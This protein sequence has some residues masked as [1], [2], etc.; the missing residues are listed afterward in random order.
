MNKF[1]KKV[2]ST[3][4]NVEGEGG[5]ASKTFEKDTSD[6]TLFP[7]IQV[8]DLSTITNENTIIAL[9]SDGIVWKSCSSVESLYII[10]KH[11]TEDV[12]VELDGIQKFKGL[13]KKISVDSWL[14]V[15]NVKREVSG[16]PLWTADDFETTQYNRLNYDTE[17]K[18]WEQ[19]QIV[20][21]TK[22]KNL[23]LQFGINKILMVIGSG[24]CFREDLDQVKLYKGTRSPLRPIMLERTR[25]WVIEELGGEDTPKGFETDDKITWLAYQSHLNYVK[26]GIH[27]YLA[28]AEDKDALGTPC[29]LA[30]F[31]T[32]SGKD[33]PKRGKF[34]YPNAWLIGDTSTGVGCLDLVVNTKKE[35]KGTGLIWLI[36][37]SFLI[38]DAADG[39]NALKHLPQKTDYADVKAYKDFADLK[40]P[41]EVLQK[42]VDLYAEFFPYGVQYT[43]HKGEDL[44]IDTMTYMNTYMLTA[45]MTRSQNDTM[46]FYKLC[47]AFKVDTSKVVNNNTMTPPKLTFIKDKAEENLD[48]LKGLY[49]DML[50]DLKGFKTKKKDDLVKIIGTIVE[51]HGKLG[52]QFDNFYEMKSELKPINKVVVKDD[53]TVEEFLTKQCKEKG[54]EASKDLMIEIIE[55]ADIVWEDSYLDSHRWYDLR[56]VVVELKGRYIK[57]A[58]YHMTGDNGMYDMGLEYS[59]SDFYFVTQDTRTIEET[60]YVSL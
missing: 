15:E 10:A 23:R 57:Y 12:E 36:A 45:Y 22:L 18:A 60:Y 8:K 4:T 20:L 37:Q 31:G 2:F 47:K 5:V 51:N 6:N 13:G 1:T 33:N 16:L 29:L 34:K 52:R 17:E 21:R 59:L 48:T 53:L 35:L 42:V 49:E 56:D 50:P 27:T 28:C 32:H 39:Y 24:K 7:E 3:T 41:K 9:D 38:G 55:E 46:D 26:T 43:S 11:K 25:R 30:S 14:G 54:L 58:Q 19:V 40:T 44:D